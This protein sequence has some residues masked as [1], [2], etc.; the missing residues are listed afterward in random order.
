MSMYNMLHGENPFADA[1]L[2]MIGVTRAECGRYRDCFLD[3]TEGVL[4]IAIYT[5]CGGGNRE[6]YEH[7]FGEMSER[8]GYLDNRDDDYDCTYATIWFAIPDKFRELCAQ[9]AGMGAVQNPQEM[10]E[11]TMR[12][13][14]TA[15]D[16]DP[17]WQR[18]KALFAPLLETIS[19]TIN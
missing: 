9:F 6:A 7:V 12:T 10:F 11:A 5:R 3:D 13:I 16:A 17:E 14:R 8:P 1:L 2:A 15:S 18:L 4:R 19:R